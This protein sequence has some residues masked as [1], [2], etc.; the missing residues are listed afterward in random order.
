[1]AEFPASAR[2][3]P[4]SPPYA[5]EVEA[6]LER[7]S[8]N[9]R[10]QPPLTIFRVWARH[11]RIG[12]ALSSIGR[13]LLQDGD[14]GSKDRELIVLRTC[15]LSGAAYEWGVH[16]SGCSRR[17]G[18]PEPLIQATVLAPTNDP[19][20]SARERLL[21][22]LVDEFESSVDVSDD[23]WAELEKV[24][25]AAQG[26]ELLLITGFYRFVAFS[27]RATRTAPEEWAPRFANHNTTGPARSA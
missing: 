23:L 21:L 16:A 2:I 8:P 10:E 17:S 20:W 6:E 5:P 14:V 3:S 22:R 18:L 4:L 12:C 13:F 7:M 26:L 24:W 11:P 1:M 25:T 19:V 27:V 15:A 9:R